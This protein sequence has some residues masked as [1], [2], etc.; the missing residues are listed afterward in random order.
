MTNKEN[1][2]ML[3]C[4][5]YFSALQIL[6][7]CFETY[8]YKIGTAMQNGNQR[9][10][11]VRLATAK[12]PTDWSGRPVYVQHCCAV[13]FISEKAAHESDLLIRIQVW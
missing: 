9:R 10:A 12:K 4:N 3:E 1:R 5:Y 6:C 7:K 11:K 8:I 2:D 13:Y